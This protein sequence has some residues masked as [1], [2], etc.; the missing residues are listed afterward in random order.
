MLPWR[1]KF[2]IAN[3][4]SNAMRQ[5]N[6]VQ[7]QK[8]VAYGDVHARSP[9]PEISPH[10]ISVMMGGAT[11]SQPLNLGAAIR[12]S[13]PMLT[14]QGQS[15]PVVT[16]PQHWV[17][18]QS[19][20]THTPRMPLASV[21]SN[22]P[23]SGGT[24][25]AAG[26]TARAHSFHRVAAHSPTPITAAR[27]AVAAYASAVPGAWPSQPLRYEYS[28]H[29]PRRLM[30][31]PRIEPPTTSFTHSSS[32]FSNGTSAAAVSTLVAETQIGSSWLHNLVSCLQ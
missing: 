1:Y 13:S 23:P 8:Q 15:R 7:Y 25:T 20:G 30:P 24:S 28:L 19:S 26:S 32:S 10:Y 9:S 18:R 11:P 2:I 22:R 29:S 21:R 27:T 31:A 4:R 6:G 17:T 14:L 5:G 3:F 12:A 16:T